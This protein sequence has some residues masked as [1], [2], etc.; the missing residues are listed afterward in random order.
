MIY[1]LFLS[2]HLG[3]LDS[4]KYFNKFI[5][6]AQQYCFT[7]R[8]LSIGIFGAHTSSCQ[9]HVSRNEEGTSSGT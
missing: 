6:R 2:Q 7:E 1:Q 5:N 4:G 3:E 9:N 8:E